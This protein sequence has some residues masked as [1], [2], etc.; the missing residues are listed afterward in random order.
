MSSSKQCYY[1]ILSHICVRFGSDWSV[2]HAF[3]VDEGESVVTEKS[4]NHLFAVGVLFV[5]SACVRL[6]RG[7]MVR[8]STCTWL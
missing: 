5:N 7:R 8:S 3:M 2:L 1:R 6:D 4:S